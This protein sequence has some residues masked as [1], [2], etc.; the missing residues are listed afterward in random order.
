MVAMTERRA[1]TVPEVSE[2]LRVSERT[3]LNWLRAGRLKGYRLGGPRAGWRI[4]RAD[5]DRFIAQQKG[6]RPDHE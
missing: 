1:L 6:E 4:E 3:V 2:E 5:V